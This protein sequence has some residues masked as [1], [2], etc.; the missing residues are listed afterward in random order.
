[1]HSTNLQKCFCPLTRG[2]AIR[3]FISGTTTFEVT[4][5]IHHG[6]LI[7]LLWWLSFLWRRHIALSAITI[8]V[9]FG[10]R[11]FVFPWQLKWGNFRSELEKMKATSW[12]KNQIKRVQ[13]LP[14]SWDLAPAEHEGP[15][16]VQLQQS[17]DR[18]LLV[19]SVGEKYFEV[20]RGKCIWKCQNYKLKQKTVFLLFS[21]YIEIS[22]WGQL[23]HS[24]S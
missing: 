20:V 3:G 11:Y 21:K 24:W 18:A 8:L 16:G 22:N 17:V 12:W 15:G 19:K 7:I 2:L 4:P 14:Y 6:V 23:G 9:F 10:Y 13:Y 1:M 5:A